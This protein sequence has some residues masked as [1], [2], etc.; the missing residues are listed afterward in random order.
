[1]QGRGVAYYRVSTKR[2]EARGL[3]LEAPRNA[4]LSYLNGGSWT[5]HGAY[6]EIE[7]G[8]SARH[9]P[10]L[11]EALA[12]AKREKA[13]LVIAKLDRLARH[14]AFISNLIESRVHFMAV[15]I[16]E[17]DKTMLPMYA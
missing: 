3:G 10:V 1:M 16:P 12:A 8:K 14:V 2:Q 11:Q 9:R 5:L 6:T 15:A 4:V 17:A 13:T 7:S